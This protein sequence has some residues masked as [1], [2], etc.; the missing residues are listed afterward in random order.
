MP[1]RIKVSS[2]KKRMTHLRRQSHLL[3][4]FRL[5]ATLAILLVLAIVLGVHAYVEDHRVSGDEG[6]PEV[7]VGTTLRARLNPEEA[8]DRPS[9]IDM[10]EESGVRPTLMQTLVITCE[11]NQIEVTAADAAQYRVVNEDGVLMLLGPDG[12]NCGRVQRIFLPA[13]ENAVKSPS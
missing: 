2:I 1:R 9:V 13:D 3:H 4:H 12:Q 10:L 8:E 11:S 5:K 7:V 6:D